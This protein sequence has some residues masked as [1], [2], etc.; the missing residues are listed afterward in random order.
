MF[1]NIVN[2]RLLIISSLILVSLDFIYIYLN[3]D[4]YKTEIRNSQGSELQQLKWSGVTIRYLSQII[5]LN[6]FVLQ[7]NGTILDSFIY[8]LI[9]YSNYIGTSYA[10]INYFDEKLAFADLLKGGSI[11]AL[12]TYLTYQVYKIIKE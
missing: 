8:G 4:W 9:I 1:N 10:T 11:M 12:T 6:L 5:G 3:Q 2:I 7:H